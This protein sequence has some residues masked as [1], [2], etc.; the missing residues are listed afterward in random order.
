MAIWKACSLVSCLLLARAESRDSA[1]TYAVYSA[2]LMIPPL[3]HLDQSKRYG[4][5][6]TTLT[7]HDRI[8]APHRACSA[9]PQVSSESLA[10]IDSDFEQHKNTAVRLKR[11]FSLPKPYVLL[12]SKQ[13]EEFEERQGSPK[14]ETDPPSLPPDP[15]P[16][17]QDL[18][19]VSD[20]YFDGAHR[21]AM[22]YV[23]AWCG[24][25]CGLWGWHVL[26]KNS[27]GDWEGT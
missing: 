14:M 26:Q 8:G 20:V 7:A 12:T 2:I 1:E 10:Q 19:R 25:L 11:A 6:E 4:I 23:S 16:G 9:I 5:V 17:I 24:L 27:R 21:T 18:V 15:F 13:A 3:S 22:V